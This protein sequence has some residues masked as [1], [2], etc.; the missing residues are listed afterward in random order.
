MSGSLTWDRDR[1]SDRGLSLT[2]R[3]SLGS[4]ASGE[5]GRLLERETLAGLGEDDGQ[6]SHARFDAELGYGLPVAG[7]RFTGTPWVGFGLSG[8]ARDYT[9]GWRF[10]PLGGGNLHLGLEATRTESANDNE[11]EHA[12]TLRLRARW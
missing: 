3:Q 11:P 8:S 9:L 6:G 12:A 7:N 5:A 2:V 10:R 1:S 4:G